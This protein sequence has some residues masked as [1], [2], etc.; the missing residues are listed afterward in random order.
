MELLLNRVAKRD[1][2]TI[3]HLYKSTDYLCDTL[4]DTWRD[5]NKVPK[6]YGHTAIPEGR[7]RVIIKLWVKH[8][9]EIPMLL[10]VP[11]FKGILIHAGNTDEDTKGC[12][13]VGENK[14]KGKLVN[15]LYHSAIITTMINEAIDNGEKVYIT[16]I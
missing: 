4:E 15:S 2:Y 9:K 3:G 13:L 8:N 11:Q 12:I 5:L 6:V 16:I 14:V 1:T 10:D 7:Y